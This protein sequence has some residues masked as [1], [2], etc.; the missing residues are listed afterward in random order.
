MV[1]INATYSHEYVN[2]SANVFY[3]DEEYGLNN[4]TLV[5]EVSDHNPIYAE[6]RT[7]LADDD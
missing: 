1:L 5:L 7:G 6:F 2:H 4:S 3:F